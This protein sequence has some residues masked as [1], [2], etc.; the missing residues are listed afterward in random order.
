MEEEIIDEIITNSKKQIAWARK[1]KKKRYLF[2]D[3]KKINKEYFIGIKGL[4][5]VGKTVLMLEL[6]E[7]IKNSI[8]FSADSTLLKLF[9]IYETVKELIKRGF[10]VMFIDEIHRK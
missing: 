3:I 4:R 10:K 1:F 2:K 7:E 6:A 5:G 9:S 8:Y